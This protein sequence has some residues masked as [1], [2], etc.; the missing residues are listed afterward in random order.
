MGTRRKTSTSKPQ[1][2]SEKGKSKPESRRKNSDTSPIDNLHDLL[3]ISEYRYRLLLEVIS[4]FSY[5]LEVLPDG[6]RQTE[7]VTPFQT[8]LMGQTP[9]A[10]M[11]P[12][13]WVEI[14]HP[15]D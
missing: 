11:R 13:I 9:Q 10:M 2:N 8:S 7:W 3:L 4:D 5:V 6:S 1:G 14:T 12:D 15:E